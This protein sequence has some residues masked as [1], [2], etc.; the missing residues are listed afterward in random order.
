[1]AGRALLIRSPVGADQHRFAPLGLQ[2]HLAMAVIARGLSVGTRE[3]VVSEDGMVKRPNRE[4]LRAL[5]VASVAVPRI[6]LLCK[7]TAVRILVACLALSVDSNEPARDRALFHSVAQAAPHRGVGAGQRKDA[8]LLQAKVGR[9]EAEPLVTIEAARVL[10]RE[11]SSVH[12]VMA[13]LAALF[14]PQIPGRARVWITLV[15]HHSRG[16][17][18][19]ALHALVGRREAKAGESVHFSSHAF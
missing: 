10:G 7:L 1:M 6:E 5:F 12:I 18:L 11:L 15:K 2:L 14:A 17:A 16:M 4:G 13:A 3:L 19:G 8:V 9:Q